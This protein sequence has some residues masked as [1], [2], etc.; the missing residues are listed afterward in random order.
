MEVSDTIRESLRGDGGLEL[1]Q[2]ERDIDALMARASSVKI[3]AAEPDVDEFIEA[4]DTE[5]LMVRRPRI[6]CGLLPIK[7]CV[8]VTRAHGVC[9]S[10]IRCCRAGR[11]QTSHWRLT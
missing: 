11:A 1:L 6:S 9:R 4:T 10:L 5:S 8:A 7:C 2:I 3:Y